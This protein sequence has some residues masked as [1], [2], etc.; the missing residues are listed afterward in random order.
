[1]SRFKTIPHHG[2]FPP[3]INHPNDISTYQGGNTLIVWTES[4]Y[5]PFDYLIYVDN[6]LLVSDSWNTGTIEFDLG[7]FLAEPW[8]IGVYN[9]TCVV[10][11]LGGNQAS[12]TV[13]VIIEE[14]P[15]TTTEIPTTITEIPS[16]K[17][18]LPTTTTETLTDTSETSESSEPPS[19]PGISSG[20]GLLSLI[21]AGIATALYRGIRRKE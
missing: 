21:S 10:W 20:F 16:T 5:D 2:D 15:P 7:K 13:L 9:V 19:V 3:S 12:D 11:D 4:D 6:N 18:E 1:M 14:K 17:T 8:S